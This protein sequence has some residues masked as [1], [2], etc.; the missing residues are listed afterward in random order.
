M[1][2]KW[3]WKFQSDIPPTNG[4][5]KFFLNGPH[6]SAFGILLFSNLEFLNCNDFFSKRSTAPLYHTG[7]TQK[8]QLSGNRAT[9]VNGVKTR[10]FFV[11]GHFRV[12]LCTCAFLRYDF[13]TILLL[14]IAAIWSY[15]FTDW[16]CSKAIFGHLVALSN[17][18]FCSI[19]IFNK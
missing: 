6:N 8:P 2:S 14:Q 1:G 13:Q 18:A 15:T 17:T 16:P 11:A 3:K 7:K 12:I 5:S 4:S 10:Q 19:N 9:V